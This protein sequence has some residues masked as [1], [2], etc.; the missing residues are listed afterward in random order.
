MTHE[1]IKTLA[2]DT[3][4]FEVES[5]EVI[6]FNAVMGSVGDVVFVEGLDSNDRLRILSNTAIEVV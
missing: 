5:G 6:R 2:K 4:I 3:E 1:T